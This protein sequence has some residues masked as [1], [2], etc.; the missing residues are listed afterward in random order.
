V[1][2]LQLI[3]NVL[4]IANHQNI[5]GVNGTAYQLSSGSSATQGVA[6]YQSTFQQATS[7]NNREFLYTPRQFEIAARLTFQCAYN[8]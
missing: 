5:N 2:D 3:G 1:D 6:T 8:T 7:I 4:N